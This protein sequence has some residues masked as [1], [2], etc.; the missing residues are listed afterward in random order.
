MPRRRAHVPAYEPAAPRQGAYERIVLGEVFEQEIDRIE[1]TPTFFPDQIGPPWPGADRRGPRTKWAEYNRDTQIIE[2]EF[3][4][5]DV[6][7]Y[8]G[9]PPQ[10][11]ETLKTQISTGQYINSVLNFYS[12]QK[13]RSGV[14]E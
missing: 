14:R 8:I 4:N 5:G 2:M 7:R 12:Y 9:V 1:P 6:Y 11:W 3:R 10:V 13:I